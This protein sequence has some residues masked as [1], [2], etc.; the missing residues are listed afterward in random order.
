MQLLGKSNSSIIIGQLTRSFRVARSKR[1]A[2]VDVEDAGAAAGR[3][4]DRGSLNLVLLGVDL[5]VFEAVA[6][7][8]G[9]AGGGLKRRR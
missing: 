2:V 4:D 1:N 9:H 7:G 5:A 3:P 8:D 6:A